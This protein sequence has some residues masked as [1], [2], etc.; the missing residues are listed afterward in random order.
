MRI[1]PP[2]GWRKWWLGAL[3]LIL[4]GVFV[5]LGLLT[6]DQWLA[7]IGLILGLGG[8]ANVME[9]REERKKAE[10]GAEEAQSQADEAQ[11]HADERAGR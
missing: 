7:A 4:S 3:A 11:T 8:F 6:G 9:H 2:Q 1:Y 5:L 10:A